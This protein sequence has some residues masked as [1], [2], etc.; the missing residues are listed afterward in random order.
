MELYAIR[1]RKSDLP[2]IT[3]LNGGVT[4]E[5]EKTP[6]YLVVKIE[7]SEHTHNEI[8][9]ERVF[10]QRFEISNRS[11]LLLKLKK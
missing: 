9:T 8:V 7:D 6:T 4:P 3:I 2:L 1:I 5:I 11:P 10:H